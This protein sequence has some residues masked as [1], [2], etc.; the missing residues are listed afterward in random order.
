M[1]EIWWSIE[2]NYG[3]YAASNGSSLLS[4]DLDTFDDSYKN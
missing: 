4:D 3:S 2:R 1:S